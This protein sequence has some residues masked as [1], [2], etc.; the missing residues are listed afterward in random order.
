MGIF[1]SIRNYFKSFK[2]SPFFHSHGPMR[3]YNNQQ[4]TNKALLVQNML[5]ACCDIGQSLPDLVDV[6]RQTH[7]SSAETQLP[8][9]HVETRKLLEAKDCCGPEQV[10]WWWSTCPRPTGSGW[11]LPLP[12]T[13]RPDA[14]F[15]FLVLAGRHLAWGEPVQRGER[16]LS[17]LLAIQVHLRSQSRISD[18]ISGWSIPRREEDQ[19]PG[20]K[21][22]CPLASVPLQPGID[23]KKNLSLISFKKPTSISEGTFS[24]GW[25][26]RRDSRHLPSVFSACARRAPCT[27][28]SHQLPRHSLANCCHHLKV[29]C[30]SALLI[31]FVFVFFLDS[32]I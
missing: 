13:F 31:V 25:R 2:L 30:A 28:V 27:M 8:K 6:H 17:L 10:R 20:L 3:N 1:G 14:D 7:F 11:S 22:K 4:Q 16:H 12:R 9:K 5:T 23:S 15:D 29:C 26:G 19:S 21:Q 32:W 18:V 24:R